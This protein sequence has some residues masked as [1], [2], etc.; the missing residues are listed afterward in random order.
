MVWFESPS[1]PL[2]KVVDIAAV[3]EITKAY[4]PEILVV[5]DNT[6]MSPYFQR[7]LNLGADVVI[8]SLTKY[9]NGHSDV[10]MGAAIT[11]SETIDNHLFFMQLGSTLDF[12]V[13]RG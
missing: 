3:V 13:R 5:V 6:F 9:V 8:H 2:L 7:P 4:N 1:N 11:N 10:V 12:R